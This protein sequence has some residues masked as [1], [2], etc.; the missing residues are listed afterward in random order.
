MDTNG[1]IVDN[2]YRHAVQLALN[3]IRNM[4]IDLVIL[5]SRSPT[6]AVKNIY[7]GSFTGRLIKGQG[8]FAQALI[9]A[10]YKVLDSE[11]FK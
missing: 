4:Q 2:E 7:D 5:Q 11:D 6:C 1:N 9:K 8:L 10:G 3:E